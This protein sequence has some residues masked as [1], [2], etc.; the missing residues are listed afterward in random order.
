[1]CFTV[2]NSCHRSNANSFPTVPN[3]CNTHSSTRSSTS[4]IEHMLLALDPFSGGRTPL[5]GSRPERTP[6]WHVGV[7]GLLLWR[8]CR[9]RRRALSEYHA[10]SRGNAEPPGTLGLL[11]GS[12]CCH[13]LSRDIPLSVRGAVPMAGS[14]IPCKC[15]QRTH[16]RAKKP[17][18]GASGEDYHTILMR[19]EFPETCFT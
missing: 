1:M 2:Q 5:G 11:R 17:S 4:E 3:P 12:P 16:R 19:R 9:L 10:S 15:E 14:G 8:D 6:V 13:G 7:E 18:R